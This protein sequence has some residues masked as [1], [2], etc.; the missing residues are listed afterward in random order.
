MS[1]TAGR[2]SY[3]YKK[4]YVPAQEMAKVLLCASI[5]GRRLMLHDWTDCMHCFCDLYVTVK[6]THEHLLHAVP[7]GM[8]APAQSNTGA[9][10]EHQVRV[11]T[12]T[13]M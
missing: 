4:V 3:Q 9:Q 5:C 13:V 10:R 12:T 8:Q 1:T 11:H 2:A 7:E 6:L